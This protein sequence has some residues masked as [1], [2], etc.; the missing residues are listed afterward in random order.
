M[1]AKDVRQK[2]KSEL[3]DELQKLRKEQMNL[4]FQQASGELQAPSRLRAI[5]KT[6]ARI[7]TILTEQASKQ[8]ASA[9]SKT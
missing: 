1:K 6:I 7:K 9:K 3:R 4:R 5:R 8:V 2:T